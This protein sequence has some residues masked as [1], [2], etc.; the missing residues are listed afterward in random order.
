VLRSPFL[1]AEQ[2]K[3]LLSGHRTKEAQLCAR[4]WGGAARF[5]A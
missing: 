4:K 2:Q 5:A 3:W 1:Y